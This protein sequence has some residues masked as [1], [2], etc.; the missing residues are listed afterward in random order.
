MKAI[1][2]EDEPLERAK[3]S[4]LLRK[5]FPDSVDVIAEASCVQEAIAL[6]SSTPCDIIFMDVELSD[7][8]CFDILDNFTPKAHLII[9]TAYDAYALKAFEV[10]SV[11]YLLKPICPADLRRAVSRCL[12]R[13]PSSIDIPLLNAALKKS[14]IL[15]SPRDTSFL[16]HFNDHILSLDIRDIP[17]FFSQSKGN[18]VLTKEGKV[19]PV[20]DSLDQVYSKLSEIDFF[21]ISRGCIVSR[22]YVHVVSKQKGRLTVVLSPEV[23]S[24]EAPGLDLVVSRSKGDDFLRWLEK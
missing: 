18:R 10:G 13:P 4:L 6:L 9:T 16:V 24:P 14:S 22:D 2:I 15:S 21:R 5:D 12:D 8:T 3:I 17:C 11:D 20:D 23:P 19:Y 1:I 7:G